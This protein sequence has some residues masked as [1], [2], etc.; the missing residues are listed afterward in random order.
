MKK[1]AL[2]ILLLAA[3]ATSADAGLFGRL[4]NRGK[5][6]YSAI[7]KSSPSC[8]RDAQGRMVCPLKK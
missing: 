4:R 1:F 8:Y 3:F 6:N 7:P 2:S 5:S